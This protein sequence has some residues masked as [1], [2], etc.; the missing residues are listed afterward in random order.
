MVET[1]VMVELRLLPRTRATWKTKKG[2]G[3]QVA[4]GAQDQRRE[5]RWMSVLRRTHQKQ[6]GRIEGSVAVAAAGSPFW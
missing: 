6:S 3:V 1:A 4:Q 5:M 2:K